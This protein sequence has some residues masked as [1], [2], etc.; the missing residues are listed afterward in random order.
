MCG[1][2]SRCFPTS[3]K[4]VHSRY[5]FSVTFS[6]F[7]FNCR[8]LPACII[9]AGSILVD[10]LIRDP[11][12]ENADEDLR[13]M[14][15]MKQLMGHFDRFMSQPVENALNEL[16]NIANYALHRNTSSTSAI[17]LPEGSMTFY[18][19]QPQVS[20][21]WIKCHRSFGKLN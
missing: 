18:P 21:S 6:V 20:E 4:C 3:P 19:V 10:N 2:S 13:L 11:F 5:S 17:Q 15:N 8:L 1:G 12:A 7:P 9:T 16:E 14:Q